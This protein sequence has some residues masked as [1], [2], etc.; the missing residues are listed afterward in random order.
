MHE[1]GRVP[2]FTWQEGYGAF[3][4]SRSNVD[5]VREYIRDQPEHHRNRTFE[6]EYVEFLRKHEVEFD[7][8]YL[9]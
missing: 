4:V 7:E 6:E 3:T 8:R 5:A 1:A 2:Q 9:W